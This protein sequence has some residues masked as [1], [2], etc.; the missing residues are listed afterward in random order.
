MLPVS[1]RIQTNKQLK[2][3]LDYELPRYGSG[4]LR[5]FFIRR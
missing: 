2:E 1:K 4:G 3:W 5:C